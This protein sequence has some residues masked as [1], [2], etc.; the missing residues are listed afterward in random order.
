[1]NTLFDLIPLNINPFMVS[2]LDSNLDSVLLLEVLY[3]F[4]YSDSD[5]EGYIHYTRNKL[6]EFTGLSENQIKKAETFL[7][8]KKIL[9]TKL[10]KGM[11]FYWLDTEKYSE[12]LGYPIYSG[13]VR[14]LTHN[15]KASYL[16]LFIHEYYNIIG[17]EIPFEIPS[18]NL[19]TLSG[20]EKNAQIY[21]RDTLLSFGLLKYEK[22]KNTK[23]YFL[24]YENINKL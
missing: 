15:S 16:L 10:E 19:E 3:R 21:A 9:K 18:M 23:K 12:L 13:L 6:M 24:N 4:Y 11:R 22:K 2:R 8:K 14:K 1:M 20:L 5:D 7:K 17:D